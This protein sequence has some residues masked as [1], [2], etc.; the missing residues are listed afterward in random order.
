MQ[1]KWSQYHL[2]REL[3]KKHS[4]STY[5]ASLINPQRGHGEPE[6]QV[7]LTVFASSL[8]SFPHERE[9][10]LQKAQ[11]IKELQHAHLL[12]ILDMGIAEGQPFV[13]REYL[14]AG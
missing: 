14:S 3:S 12:P 1:E 2:T 7:I 9:K 6:R 4:H 5:L 8:F 10:L 11:R 13:V